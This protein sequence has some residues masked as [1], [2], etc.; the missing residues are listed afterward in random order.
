MVTA[1][2]PSAAVSAAPVMSP[3]VAAIVKSYGS[4]S[5]EPTCPFDAAV[6]I[7]AVSAT[8]TC[9]AEVSMKPPLPPLG[10][11]ASSVPLI[12]TVPFF[13]SASREM[14]PPPTPVALTVP[15]MSALWLALNTILPPCIVAL[16]ALAVPVLLTRA[17]NSPKLPASATSF[18]ILVALPAGAVMVT[19]RLGSR[20]FTSC[21]L[22]PATRKISPL[23]AVMM[24]VFSTLGAIK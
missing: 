18:P 4:I 7:R 8:L 14:L 10:A 9:A 21:T 15:P 1:P 2:T 19:A 13:L 3:P 23:G 12:L 22:D 16:S 17:P 6:V 5:Q 20:L 11:E 24:P